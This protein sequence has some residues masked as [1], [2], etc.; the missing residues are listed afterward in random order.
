M[1]NFPNNPYSS[2]NYTDSSL[3]NS[4]QQPPLA[5]LGKR[6]LGALADGFVGLIFVGPGYGLMVAGVAG[7]PD[8][9]ELPTISIVGMGL[10]VLGALA[11]LGVQL[12]LLATRSQSI[13]KLLVKT[14][15]WDVTTGQPAGFVKAFVLRAIVH[16]LITGIPCVGSIY[17]LV[18]IFFIFREDRRCIHDL[19][20]ST[21]VLDI[22]NR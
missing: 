10:L 19:I 9:S 14:Q 11:L 22:E 15:I 6:F 17:A 12:Y 5:S 4:G 1:S 2:P 16:G 21:V 8:Q 20:A 3:L 13:G 18:D 7:N